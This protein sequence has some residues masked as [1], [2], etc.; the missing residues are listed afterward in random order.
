MDLP[1]VELINFIISVDFGCTVND[2][3]FYQELALSALT[4]MY[5]SHIHLVTHLV[6][7]MGLCG[8]E[9]GYNT[10]RYFGELFNYKIDPHGAAILQD[11]NFM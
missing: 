4:T 7:D 6:F 5:C 2:T 11:G 10:S 3:L 9:K 8:L 1:T